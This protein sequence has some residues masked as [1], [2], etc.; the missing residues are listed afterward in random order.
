MDPTST[1]FY[2]SKSQ[3]PNSH[4]RKRNEPCLYR[5]EI[6]RPESKKQK[7]DHQ[8]PKFYLPSDPSSNP[9]SDPSSYYIPPP[10]FWDTL[11]KIWLT[12]DA[13][14]ELDRRNAQSD[15]ES[16]Y[17]HQEAQRPITRKF[18]AELR[19][20]QSTRAVENF[21][22]GPRIPKEIQQFARQG[23]PNI[24]DLRGVRIAKCLT[25]ILDLTVLP[26]FVNLS[27]LCISP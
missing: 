5:S 26:S 22:R 9:S 19:H 13:L 10:S 6:F 11:S 2:M 8:P 23:G 3:A 12:K 15:L 4:K 16:S 24:S 27:I 21:F 25:S 14:R 17:H 1:D 7:L 18:L 20:R